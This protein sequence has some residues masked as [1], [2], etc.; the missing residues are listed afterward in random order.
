MKE[1]TELAEVLTASVEPIKTAIALLVYFA[2]RA[3]IR[4][5]ERQVEHWRERQR[6]RDFVALRGTRRRDLI[7]LQSGKAQG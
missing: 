3:V 4:Q 7:R 2:G 6:V 1:L 5:T